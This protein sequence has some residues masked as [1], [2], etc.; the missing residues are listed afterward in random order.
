MRRIADFDYIATETETDALVLENQLIKEYRPRY[1]V[2]LKDD[3]Q[4]PYLRISL[5]EPYPRV[6]V[7]R[8][9]AATGP[10][11]SAPTPTCGPCARP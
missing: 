2:R 11:T 3:K 8:R 7:V 1:N 9:I 10:A 6:E 5:E 4:Y